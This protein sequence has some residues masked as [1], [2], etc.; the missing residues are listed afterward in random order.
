MA[1]LHD[2][3]ARL[4]GGALDDIRVIEVGQLVAG[5][6]CGQLLA[7][8]GAEVIKVEPPGEGDP[9]RNWGR[10]KSGG[11]SLWWPIV[12]R[13]KKSI[14][15]DLHKPEGQRLLRE[16]AATA[17]VLIEN[18][19]PGTLE[20]W[21]LG[22]DDLASVNPRLVMIR[23]TGFGQDGPYSSQPGYGSIGEAMG[24][25][26]YVMGEPD[27]PP[28]R[29][30]ISIG[31]TI[32]ALFACIGGLMA[33]HARERTGRGQV[34]DAALYEAVLAVMESL[35]SEYDTTGYIRERTGG[36]LPNIAPS[37][38]YPTADGLM[39]LIAANQDTVFRRLCEAMGRAELATD[40]RYM[41]HLARGDH[42]KELDDLIASWTATLDAQTLR[43]ILVAHSVPNGWIY[44]APEMLAD[45][46][47]AA[48]DAIVRVSHP[49]LGELA[50]QN[51]A[52]RLSATPGAIQWVGPELGAHNDEILGTVL[53]LSE[54]ERAVL[55]AAGV[56]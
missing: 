48:R 16:L 36:V 22:Y 9:M 53:G 46:H 13:N 24:G 28:S 32:A 5:P 47:F 23:V 42:Q 14:T 49:E 26:R 15:L 6:F 11:L 35:I 38:A 37:N 20:R 52:P 44:R 21:G 7:D 27:H 40:P 19:R 51:V 56:I 41:T 3:A 55:R 8:F 1:T 10:E 54:V 17:D 2:V 34:V 39:I 43:E 31:D 29:A 33:L 12:A 30:G 45:P 25:L 4:A 50:M 18:M